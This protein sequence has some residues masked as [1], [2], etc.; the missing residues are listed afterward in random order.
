MEIHKLTF[1]PARL[2]AAPCKRLSAFLLLGHFLSEAN[3][4]QK[5]LLVAT[6]D[7]SGGKHDSDARMSLALLVT[8]VFLSKIDE[9]WKRIE[10]EPLN[11]TLSALTT[12]LTAS[13]RYTALQARLAKDSLVHRIRNDV[14][15]HYP[16]SLSL[17][18]LPGIAP[19]D[20]GIYMT[21]H[22]G[23]TLS[24]ISVLTGVQF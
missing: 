7:R 14:G 13:P 8:R 10:T 2:R 23:D 5:L 3:W 15:F 21:D 11:G 1:D 16:T 22:A 6:Q 17:Q 20:V 4:L 18:G 19:D 9:G 12:T 24:F